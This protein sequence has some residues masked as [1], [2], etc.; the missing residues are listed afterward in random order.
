LPLFDANS[1]RALLA[2]AETGTL[3]DL[4]TGAELWSAPAPEG[5]LGTALIQGTS[6]AALIGNREARLFAMEDGRQVAAYPLGDADV[7]IAAFDKDGRNLAYMSGD[8]MAIIDLTTGTIRTIESVG[9][10]VATLSFAP[11]LST[12]LIGRRNGSI[13]ARAMDGTELWT[14]ASPLG[15]TFTED[16]AW[17]DMPPKGTVLQIAFSP[18]GKRFAV[19]RQDL[20][21]LDLYEGGTGRFLTAL[22]PPWPYG[23]PASV[24]LPD[25]TRVLSTWAYHAMTR[26][27]PAYVASHTIP[28]TLPEALEL[29]RDRLAALQA[30]WTPMATEL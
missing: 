5:M 6:L 23:V 27:A 21:T 11:D 19:I 28:G 1:G 25:E 3:Y 20:P 24:E 7:S 9:S 29:A 13:S 12:I 22:T 4:Q 17:P 10:D 15:D 30:V 2:T 14:I 8:N 26:F 18:E 16:N